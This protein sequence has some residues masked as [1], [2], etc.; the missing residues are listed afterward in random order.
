MTGRIYY[1]CCDCGR[2]TFCE[3]LAELPDP[4]RCWTCHA[5]RVLAYIEPNPIFVVAD[6]LGAALAAV[7]SASDSGG[8]V[9][10]L[11]CGRNAVRE[12]A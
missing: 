1:G 4:P 8:K 10:V 6:R 9:V 11:L 7:Q 2:H 5:V 3:G 12:V